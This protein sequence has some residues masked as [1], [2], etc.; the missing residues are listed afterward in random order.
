MTSIS[1]KDYLNMQE[2]VEKLCQD[3][4]TNLWTDFSD[5]KILSEEENIYRITLQSQD[6]SLL[7]G[8]HG[9]NIEIITHLLKLLIIKQT[10]SYIHIHLEINDYQQ[11]KDEKLI[12]FIASKIKLAQESGREIV[13]P[14]FTAYERKK[15]HSYVSTAWWNIYTASKWEWKDRRIHLQ[16]KD[17]KMT[18][19]IDGDDI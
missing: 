8:P 18:I 4:F 15:V 19:D 17:E 5:L 1:F 13:L 10:K 14:Y 12:A 3:F 11:K 16:K 7:I 9:K 2:W 6:S